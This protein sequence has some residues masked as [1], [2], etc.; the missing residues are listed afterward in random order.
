M[1]AQGITA[2]QVN[3][4]LRAINVNAAGGRAEIAGSEQSVRVLGNALT[5]HALGE[6]QMSIG[7]GRTI[8][9]NSI[10]SVR[11]HGPS[12]QLRQSRTAA[13]WSAS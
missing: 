1:Q 10:A 3:Q 11:D 2:T 6:T 13:R 7:G 12:S 5:A 9:L 8:R 4:Q